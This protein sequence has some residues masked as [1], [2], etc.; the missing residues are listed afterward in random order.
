M[1]EPG[2]QGEERAGEEEFKSSLVK[3][4]DVR[5]D[6]MKIIGDFEPLLHANLC[7]KPK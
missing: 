1:E 7:A 6:K 5:R 3:G 4:P 2:S